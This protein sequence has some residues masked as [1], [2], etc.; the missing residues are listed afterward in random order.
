VLSQIDGPV[1][2]VGHSYGG[3]VITN[4]GTG[5]PNVLA[6][7]YVSGSA[8]DEDETMGAVASRSKDSVLNNALVARRYS[9]GPAGQTATEFGIHP[10]K[11]HD[12]FAAD[13]RRTSPR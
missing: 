7:V 13:L 11:F 5:D 9:A 2:L 1:L 10:A 8:P 4:T 6:L 12:A 3:A